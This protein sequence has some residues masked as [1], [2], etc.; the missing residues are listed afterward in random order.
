MPLSIKYQ[1]IR[2]SKRIKNQAI[3]YYFHLIYSPRIFINILVFELF[4][5]VLAQGYFALNIIW[6]N[7]KCAA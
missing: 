5:F 2:T 6:Q 1:R 7:R 3:G 4:H